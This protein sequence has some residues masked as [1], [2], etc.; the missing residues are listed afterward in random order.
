MLQAS[1]HK[2]LVVVPTYNCRDQI[3]K[4]LTDIKKYAIPDNVTIWIVDNLS[5][6][7]TF[8]SAKKFIHES[9]LTRIYAYQSV[10]N[11]NLGGTHKIGFNEAINNGYEFVAIFHGDNQANYLDLIAI[12]KSE[13]LSASKGS[14]LGARFAKG[15]KLRGYSKMRILGNLVLNCIYS[16]FTFHKLLDLGSGLNVYRVKDLQ[17]IDFHGF[18]DSLTFNYELILA[19]VELGLPF[20]Y[21]PI[22]WSNDDQVSNA[23]NLEIF[24][25]GVRI[26]IGRKMLKSNKSPRNNKIYEVKFTTNE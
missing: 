10:E 11:N 2:I 23:R 22:S 4:V 9:N 26:L 16:M 15:S 12:L 24:F 21:V 19:I 8:E 14:I 6:D 17:R 7:G 20:K 18:S 25:K 5:Q 3:L 1:M 13:E